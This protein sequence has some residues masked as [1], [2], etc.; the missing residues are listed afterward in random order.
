MLEFQI[1][2][3]I[4]SES[5]I[6]GPLTMVQFFFLGGAGFLIVIFYFAT[7]SLLM[8]ILFMA[9]VG[10]PAAFLAFGKYNGEKAINVLLHF[11]IHLK[12]PK[13]YV[14]QTKGEEGGM[15]LREVER[16]IEEKEKRVEKTT[17]ESK[18]REIASKLQRGVI[19]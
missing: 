8:T 15:V 12:S 6:V 5:K 11:F 18:L 2:Q 3:F 17:R 10:G 7:K 1:P 19:G 9:G 16:I 4:E 14:W 13:L